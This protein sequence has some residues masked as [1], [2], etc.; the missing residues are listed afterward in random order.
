[1]AVGQAGYFNRG[2]QV[3]SNREFIARAAYARLAFGVQKDILAMQSRTV[4]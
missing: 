1:M 4:G 2:M 3:K